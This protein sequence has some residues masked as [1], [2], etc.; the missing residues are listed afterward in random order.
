MAAVFMS[1]NCLLLLIGNAIR[2]GYSSSRLHRVTVTPL[3]RPAT[4]LSTSRTSRLWQPLT[5]LR[6]FTTSPVTYKK[7]GG[8]KGKGNGSSASSSDEPDLGF[9]A[10]QKS[11]DDAIARMKDAISKLRTGGRFNPQ[12]IEQLRVSLDRKKDSAKLGDI[13]QVIPKGGRNVVILLGDE[14]HAKLVSSAISSS[15]LS[16]NAQP[17]PH[18]PLQLNI[19]IPPPTRESRDAT[20]KEARGHMEKAVQAIKNA[21]Q[22]VNKKLKDMGQKKVLQPDALHA[23]L[24]DMEKIVQAGQKSVKDAWDAAQRALQQ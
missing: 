1:R 2:S 14:A 13:A 18:N 8:G 17:D 24:K 3:L 19:P 9:D 11:I 21:R 6:A 4:G 23:A 5:S 22:D 7:K 12:L 15:N 10:L 16:L 20:V